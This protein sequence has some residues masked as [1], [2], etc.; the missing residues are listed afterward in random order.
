MIIPGVINKNYRQDMA[1]VRTRTQWTLT[2]FLL[3]IVFTFPIY[4]NTYWAGFLIFISITIIAVLGLH[5]LTGLCGQFSLGQSAF[6]AVGAYASAVFI[7]KLHVSPWLTLPLSGITAGL[8]GGVFG[9][10][11]VR[12]KGFYLAMATLAA[13]FIIV[14]VLMHWKSVTGGSDG[15]VIPSLTVGAFSFSKGNNLC[16]LAMALALVMAIFAKNI[17]RTRL[18]RAFIAIRDNDLAAE[19]M[20]VN[21]FRYKFLAFFIGCFY[22]G[23]AGWLW[24]YY[25]RS[26]NPEQFGVNESIWMLG[27]LIVGGMGSASGA[28]MGSVFIRLI[29]LFAQ[30]LSTVI[31]QVF[32]NVGLAAFSATGLIVFALVV[33]L[34][35][36]FEPRGLYHRWE[37]GKASVR[38]HPYA[39]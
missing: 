15:L 9:F 6:L 35:L 18:G 21:L 31:S 20:G 8:V 13:Q 1:I 19:M 16:Y 4:L 33:V 29:D 2:V 10:S 26:I 25:V 12:V 5:I 24:N 39:R 22:A 11:A 38:L 7:V 36:V 23:I 32:P 28:I 37:I 14:W 30:Y 27:M 34:F 3:V 17:Q